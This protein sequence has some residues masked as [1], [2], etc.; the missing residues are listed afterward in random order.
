M[1]KIVRIL[2][3]LLIPVLMFIMAGGLTN[4]VTALLTIGAVLALIAL[5]AA[6]SLLIY[7][8]F[9]L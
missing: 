9:D 3:I 1:K 6:L 8:A 4:V 5:A 2:I 7:W